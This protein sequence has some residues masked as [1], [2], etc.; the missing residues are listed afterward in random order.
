MPWRTWGDKTARMAVA[1]PTQRR[2]D[3][4]GHPLPR[5]H[6]CPQGAAPGGGGRAHAGLASCC[7]RRPSPT[8]PR[9]GSGSRAAHVGWLTLALGFEILSFLGHI[10]LFSAVAQAA[11]SRIGLW[12][13]AQINLA[14]H[15][16]TRL[17]A[18]ASA[19][20]IALTAWAMRRSGMERSDVAS[21]M[22][23][24]LRAAL[25]RLHGRAGRR[26]HRP[27]HRPAPRRRLV[28]P[29]RI[30]PAIFGGAVIAAVAAAPVGQAPARAA[31]AR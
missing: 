5:R 20:G 23:T 31:S 21:R 30:V 14:G 2:S 1:A 24:F 25:R 8:S 3:R 26:R 6:L 17:F 7:S 22:T 9:R 19:G 16:A 18:S 28:R 29:S 15:A 4:R 10:I 11:G 12:A 27:L 13:G